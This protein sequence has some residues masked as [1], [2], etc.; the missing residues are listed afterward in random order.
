[1][2]LRLACRWDCKQIA[3]YSVKRLKFIEESGLELLQEVEALMQGYG[4]EY[5]IALQ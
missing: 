3:H 1:M 4:F 2:H 5:T